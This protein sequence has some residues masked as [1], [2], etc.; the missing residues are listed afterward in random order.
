MTRFGWM[1]AVSLLFA[2][3]VLAMKCQ[4]LF[5]EGADSIEDYDNADDGGDSSVR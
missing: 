3:S 4:A 1:L 2:G 5:D